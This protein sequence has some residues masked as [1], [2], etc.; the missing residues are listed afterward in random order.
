VVMGLEAVVEPQKVNVKV[1]AI[2][3]A[4]SAVGLEAV[5]FVL[6]YNNQCF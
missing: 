1:N 4:T 3:Q 5:V 2:Q 6:I